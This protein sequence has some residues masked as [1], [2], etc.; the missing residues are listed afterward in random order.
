M[1]TDSPP[2]SRLSPPPFA[3]TVDPRFF[4]RTRQHERALNRV[5]HVIRGHRA[6][7][8]V[9]GESG[10]GKTLTSQQ[11]LQELRD[12]EYVPVLVLAYPGMSRLA[13]LQ[14]IC[15][16]LGVTEKGRYTT[17]W[18]HALE[19]W[20]IDQ[21]REGR[22]LVILVDEAH[23]LSSDAL[24][25]LRTI[26]NLETP[27]EKL[28]TT[29]LFSETGLLRRLRHPGYAALRGRICQEIELLP[30]TREETEQYVKFRLLVAGLS[31]A[32]FDDEALAAIFQLSRG[33][34]RE[35]SRVADAALLEASCNNAPA[36]DAQQV[37]AVGRQRYA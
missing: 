36:V 31:P 15:S 3:D 17:D 5:L 32:M 6:L 16:E 34:P 4:F 11:L 29:V 10:T 13:V 2:V 1:Y 23:F 19:R 22:R 21:H 35:I 8:L 7:A 18:L 12:S 9:Y 30:L 20:V 25:L 26:S 24:H 27:M 28:V 33:V 37:L 14:Q